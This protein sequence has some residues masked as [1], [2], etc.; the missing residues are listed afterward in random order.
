MWRAMS[1][2]DCLPA[3]LRGPTTIISRVAAGQSG[4]GVYRV[5]AGGSAFVLKVASEDEPLAEWRRKRAIQKLAADASLAPRVVH[6]DEARRAHVS[7]FVADR[8]FIAFYANP[9]THDDALAQL[10]QTLRRVHEL[11]PPPGTD[12][13]SGREWLAVIWPGLASSVSLPGF[14]R[15]A[16]ERVLAEEPPPSERAFVLSHNDVN[17]TNLVY[18]GQSCWLLDWD[19]AG[20][21][22]PFV[23][24]A[25]VSVFLRMDERTCGE[26]L[27]AYDGEPAPTTLP[28]RFA[29]SRR[30][31]AAFA[32][33]M[34]LH[35]AQQ[36]GHA[37]AG[38]AK[39]IDSAPSLADVYQRM[40]SGALNL[41]TGEGKWWFGLALVKASA[42]L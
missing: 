22:D 4:A 41:S 3:D 14:V 11:P 6:V 5:D 16:I 40:R 10:G 18:D 32:G 28:A 13:R 15:D 23:D 35:L 33:A 24:L 36:S 42:A 8:S 38:S 26:L 39:T 20:A 19:A 37:D 12:G 29:Y 34:M 25:T 17:P 30:L 7:A 9:S 27:S 2:E 21:N 1:L 31:V